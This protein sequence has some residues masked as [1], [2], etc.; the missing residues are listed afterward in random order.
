MKLCGHCNHIHT[1]ETED[2]TGYTSVQEAVQ[3]HPNSHYDLNI[4]VWPKDGKTKQLLSMYC[5]TRGKFTRLAEVD[6]DGENCSNQG[7]NIDGRL[8]ALQSY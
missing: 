3:K 4:M 2:G 1:Q 8:T 7:H 5:H 6:K